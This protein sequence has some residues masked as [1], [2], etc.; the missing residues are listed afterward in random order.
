MVG[1][2]NSRPHILKSNFSGSGQFF[3]CV[4]N[5]PS[6]LRNIQDRKTLNRGVNTGVGKNFRFSTST[7][8]R[9]SRNGTRLAH[10]YYDS[11]IGSHSYPI[12]PCQFRWRWVTLN[13]GTRGTQ[14]FQ[15]FF[16]V[17]TYKTRIVWSTAIK[18]GMWWRGEFLRCHP[19]SP[20][21]AHPKFWDSLRTPIPFDLVTQVGRGVFL[22]H[23]PHFPTHGGWA[24]RSQIFRT[25]I[26]IG[27]H[28]AW[29]KATKFDLGTHDS[30]SYPSM[31]EACFTVEHAPT[32]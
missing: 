24:E 5:Y 1:R 23:L 13:D 21:P 28:I 16:L 26:P 25:P 30:R 7:G 27:P 17:L 15:R 3:S 2:T 20:S 19:C 8:R 14:I 11:L 32:T 10:S 18:F 4:T 12:D 6:L 29:P 9:L 22:G 31:E